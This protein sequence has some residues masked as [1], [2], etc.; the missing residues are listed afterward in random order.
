MTVTPGEI[1]VRKGSSN[2]GNISFWIVFV[3]TKK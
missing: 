2:T 3:Y 1:V